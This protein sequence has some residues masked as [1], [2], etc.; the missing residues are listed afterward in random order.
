MYND[1][2]I[3]YEIA[4]CLVFLF[5]AEAGI[6]DFCLSRGRGDVYKRQFFFFQ[7]EDGIRDRSPS[8]GLGDVYKRQDNKVYYKRYIRCCCNSA[9]YNETNEPYYKNNNYSS[10]GF[11]GNHMAGKV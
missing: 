3:T 1:L 11:Y 4:A 5:Q 10:I 2:Y 8:R 6:R 9:I 7:A